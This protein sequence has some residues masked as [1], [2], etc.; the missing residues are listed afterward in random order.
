METFEKGKEILGNI[1][2]VAGI[3]I[4]IFGIIQ[5]FT[6]LGSQNSDS[7]NHSGYVIAAGIGVMVVGK[8][9]I[10]MISG[11]VVWS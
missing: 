9:L 11:E 4:L 6:S 2:V 3:V 7:K 5:L 10:P 1:T 8:V